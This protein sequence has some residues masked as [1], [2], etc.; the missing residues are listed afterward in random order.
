MG[1][2][3]PKLERKEMTHNV[4]YQFCRTIPE[5]E[6]FGITNGRDCYC[7]PFFHQAPGD[8]SDCDAPCDGDTSNICGGEHKSS[9]FELHACNDAVE[10]LKKASEK[11]VS[12][13]EALSEIQG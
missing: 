12:A 5:M 9:V 7:M 13:H 8:S 4:C 2:I 1:D 11:E 3:I 6:F 10:N